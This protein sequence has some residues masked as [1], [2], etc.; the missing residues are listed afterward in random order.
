MIA[1]REYQ[2]NGIQWALKKKR[3]M[4]ADEPGLG[5]TF[6]AT[7]V[8]DRANAFPCVIF[9]RGHLV[10]QWAK[11]IK[12]Q[13]PF[14][15]VSYA[16]RA[17]FY[18][19][20]WALQ[21]NA[22]FF[23]ANIEMLR[24]ID[25]FNWP[26]QIKALV[27]DESHH[28][29]NRNSKQSQ[30]ALKLVF[31]FKPEYIM[32]L[33]ATPIKREADDL[34]A[35][36]RLL[37]P[38]IFRSYDVFVKTFCDTEDTP[39]GMRVLGVQN[40]ADLMKLLEL[41]MLRRE[42]KE[43]GVEL[44]ELIE[45]VIP[46]EFNEKQAKAYKT[47]RDNLILEADGMDSIPY[48][49]KI[50]AMQMLRRMT[51]TDEKVQACV[52]LAQDADRPV[53][54][55]HYKDTAYRIA[56]LLNVPAITGDIPAEK[57]TELAISQTIV[58]ATIDSITEGINGLEDR[59]TVIFAEEDYTPGTNY[60][61]LRRVLRFGANPDKPIIKYCVHIEDSIDERIHAITERRAGTSADLLDS[62]LELSPRQIAGVI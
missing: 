23:V 16:K 57:R 5:K 15:T 31:Q 8:A 11:F 62:V 27:F 41:I 30:G 21:K 52:D 4:I 61:A 13:Y 29:K 42:Y 59:D 10:D 49:W 33:S 2:E 54:F 48:M 3:C 58:V 22:D 40:K 53:V 19:R 35:Q 20:D 7:E 37:R 6:Q 47:L 51:A 38:D 36:L 44:P 50:Q 9:T 32:C 28:L 14:R 17:D 39:W 60:Q 1:P 12:S 34:F 18:L 25:D 45:S 55:T 56:K 26:K 43:V 24:N 46:I